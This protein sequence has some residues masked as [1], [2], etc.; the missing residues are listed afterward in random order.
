MIGTTD[1]GTR[2][3]ANAP[4]ERDTLE[5]LVAG[6]AIGLDGSLTKKDELTIFSP[7]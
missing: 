2:F 3:I 6:E 1:Q 4:F 5:D 7:A